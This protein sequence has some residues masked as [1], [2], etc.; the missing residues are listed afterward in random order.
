MDGL[1]AQ[2]PVLGVERSRDGTKAGDEFP[3]L[4]ESV[5]VVAVLLPCVNGIC[6]LAFHVVLGQVERDA[7]Q[8]RPEVGARTPR[9]VI[10]V[11]QSVDSRLLSRGEREPDAAA[12]D[13]LEARHHD[14]AAWPH[15]G[16]PG[17]VGQGRGGQHHHV[18]DIACRPAGIGPVD[19]R[20]PGERQNHG[21]VAGRCG[22]SRMKKVLLP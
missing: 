3:L 11:E 22:I 16:Q 5:L 15:L 8:D 17:R 14:V 19:H 9:Y 2:S 4:D 7:S 18:Y 10:D 1:G 21:Q 20:D 13:R 12:V 6:E